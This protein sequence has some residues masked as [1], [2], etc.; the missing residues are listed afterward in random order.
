MNS[1]PKIISVI[2]FGLFLL[3]VSYIL[4]FTNYKNI[5]NTLAKM[6]VIFE[7]YALALYLINQYKKSKNG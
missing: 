7:I 2:T 4:H 5:A 6:G 1:R 3:V